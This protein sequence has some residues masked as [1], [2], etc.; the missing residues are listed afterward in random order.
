[1]HQAGLSVK[2]GLDRETALGALTINPARIVGVEDR[3]GSIEPG[4]DADLVVWSDDPLD[5]LSRVEHAL[6]DGTE[7]YTFADG[8]ARFIEVG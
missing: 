6:I 1:V 3:L 7:I 5:V 4:K 2:H 8:E